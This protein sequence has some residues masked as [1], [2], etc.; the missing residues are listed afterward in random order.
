MIIVLRLGHRKARDKRVS[1]HV[2]LVARAFG[3]DKIIFAG[4]DDPGLIKSI[5]GVTR[6]W[7]GNFKAKYVED[8]FKELLALKKKG[9]VAVHLTMYGLSFRKKMAEVRTRLKKLVIVVGA[10]KVPG[11][12][13]KEADYNLAVGNQP[14]SEVAALAI[15]LNE[16]DSSAIEKKIIGR[17][18]EIVPCERGKRVLTTKTAKTSK[19]L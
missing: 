8:G 13:Y 18:R 1:T 6:A 15:F 4:E 2:G 10:E 17:E 9:F 12:F 14:H 5:E 19:N 3:A 11:E 16:L 7:G